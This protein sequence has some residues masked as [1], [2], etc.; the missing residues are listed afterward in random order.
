MNQSQNFCKECGTQLSEEVKF[1]PNCGQ[2]IQASKEVPLSEKQGNISVDNV[3]LKAVAVHLFKNGPAWSIVQ[4]QGDTLYVNYKEDD[5]K[6]SCL[7]GCLLLLIMWPIAIVYAILGGKKGKAGNIVI[8]VKDKKIHISGDSRV[9]LKAYGILGRKPGLEDKV[10][11]TE[12]I[13]TA[14]KA[15]TITVVLVLVIVVI[16]IIALQSNSGY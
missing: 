2:S 6:A 11:E 14:K 7:G 1:C 4:E 15:Q 10:V 16:L 3:M 8:Q 9:A 5:K 12:T 13:K